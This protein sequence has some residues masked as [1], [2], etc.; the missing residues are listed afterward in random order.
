MPKRVLVGKVKSN[1]GEKT[2]IVRVER[3]KNHPL[4]KKVIKFGKSFPA[5][6]ETNIANIGDTVSIE[7][8]APK[9]KTKTWVLK[10]VVEKAL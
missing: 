3:K 8:C 7:E 9:S 10:E 4:Y 5:H 1:K 2:I 6:D